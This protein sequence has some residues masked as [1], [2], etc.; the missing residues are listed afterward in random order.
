MH[1]HVQSRHVH[2]TRCEELEEQVRQLKALLAPP[3]LFPDEW[4]LTKRET[5]L[6]QAFLVQRQLSRE[7]LLTVMYDHE[8]DIDIRTIDAFVYKLRKKFEAAGVAVTIEP[9]RSIGYRM[10]GAD[11]KYIRTF[12]AEG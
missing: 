1:Q 3:V 9:V 5:Q 7:H 2:C 6:L 8:T 12:M 11:Q 4:N 10:S